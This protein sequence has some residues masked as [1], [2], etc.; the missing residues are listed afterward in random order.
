MSLR[1]LNQRVK[2]LLEEEDSVSETGRDS[3]QKE[4]TAQEESLLAK[5]INNVMSRIQ[6]YPIVTTVIWFFLSLDRMSDDIRIWSN[7]K[8]GKTI[9]PPDYHD[10][11]VLMYLKRTSIG[12]HNIVGSIRGII[13]F[14]T[15]YRTDTKLFTSIKNSFF[16][17]CRKRNSQAEIE[18]T[19]KSAAEKPL[20]TSEEEI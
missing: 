20:V 15:F 7:Y 6:Y 13:Y 2:L 14:L 11:E 10:H 5:Q 1:Y 12:M 18:S 17:C 19:V 8:P 16:N 4:Q 9:Q 3:V